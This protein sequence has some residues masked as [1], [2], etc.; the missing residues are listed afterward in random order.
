MSY[1]IT[2]YTAEIAQ[3]IID[4]LHCGRSLRAV[5]RDPG[6]PPYSTVRQWISDDREGFAMRY[7]QARTITT[8]GRPTIYNAV[9]A[10]WIVEQL[11][12]G[13]PLAHVCGDPGMPSHV[14]VRQW[15]KDDR[16]GFAQRYKTA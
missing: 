14:T 8:A 15:E 5:C 13:R 9:I 10:D 4:E 16:E 1:A 12:E 2:T 7:R 3:W 11:T 6:M